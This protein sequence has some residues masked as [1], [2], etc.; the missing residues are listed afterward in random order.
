MGQWVTVN[1]A[2]YEAGVTVRFLP[3]Y[4]PD[5]NPFEKAFSR[6]KAMNRKVGERI[7]SGL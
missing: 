5:F 1:A 2:W 3:P 6:L 4:S 7:V